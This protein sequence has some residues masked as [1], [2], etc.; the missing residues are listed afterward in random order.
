MC[1]YNPNN[2]AQTYFSIGDAI[3]ALAFTLAVQQFLKPIYKFR[4]RVVGI[5]F[6]YVVY[7]VFAGA[8]CALIATL[9]PSTMLIANTPLG[10][11]INWEILGG[12]IVASAYAA[13]AWISL[14]PAV[15]TKRNMHEFMRG[16][17]L[18]LSEANSEDRSAFA[19]DVLH[20]TNIETLA[21]LASEFQRA[22]WHASTIAWEKLREEGREN[23][24][25]SG[26][27]E[28]TAFY[29]F[30]HR[31][32]LSRASSAWHLLQFLSEREFCQVV[33]SRHSWLFLR[34]ILPIAEKK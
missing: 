31:K 28:I 23:E 11:P 18:L 32:Q 25:L 14:T 33:A 29:Q 22:E 15:V 8:L 26:R 3:A 1:R 2:P 5:E 12:L 20:K 7:A 16:G 17:A 13:V 27:R 9:V 10:Y 19:Q 6:S 34:A 21:K 4:L 30:A 24:G